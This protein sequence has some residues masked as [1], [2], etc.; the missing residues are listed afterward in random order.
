M[1]EEEEST[2]EDSNESDEEELPST[3]PPDQKT[4]KSLNTR[5]S[6]RKKPGPVYRSL[7]APKY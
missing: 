2:D 7:F 3:L 6:D 5:P 1:E 4:M